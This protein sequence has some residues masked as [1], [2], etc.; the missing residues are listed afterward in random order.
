MYRS[1]DSEVAQDLL[2]SNFCCPH[3]LISH[4]LSPVAIGFAHTVSVMTELFH[5][6]SD[7]G[8]LSYIPEHLYDS[9]QIH[10][11]FFQGRNQRPHRICVARVA[12]ESSLHRRKTSSKS[13]ILEKLAAP[14]ENAKR[15]LR[16]FIDL[17]FTPST[18]E[19][20]ERASRRSSVST[21]R[22]SDASHADS[23]R[24]SWATGEMRSSPRNS[25]SIGGPRPALTDSHRSSA[26]QSAK[27]I[28]NSVVKPVA[29]E[30]P[31]ASGNGINVSI[32]LTEPLLFL[33]GFEHSE[34]SERSTAMLRGSLQLQVSKPTKVKAISLKFRGRATTKWPEGD[35]PSRRLTSLPSSRS[36][37]NE[38]KAFPLKRLTLKRPTLS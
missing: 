5:I 21:T 35:N 18:R 16:S 20:D 25:V 29:E 4:F 14:R 6:Y 30:K 13:Y 15:F 3:N 36:P 10:R 12:P 38:M 23:R 9:S 27:N 24:W 37:A 2:L 22:A 19:N 17:H 32:Q 7:R 26:R 11:G 31:L 1:Y 28:V 34:S 33:Q 8:R